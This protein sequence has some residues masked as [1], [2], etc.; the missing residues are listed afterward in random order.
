ML[1][2][3][4]VSNFRSIQEEIVLSLESGASKDLLDNCFVPAG[5][6]ELRLLKSAVLYGPNASGKSNV[7][8]A[9]Y[10]MHFFV[11]NSESFQ[12]GENIPCYDPF[13]LEPGA[14]S[15]PSAFRVKFIGSD[16]RIYIYQI[17]FNKEKIISETLDFYPTH[18]KAN[19]FTR[20]EDCE[21]KLGKYF[22]DK[23]IDKKIIK[24]RLFLSKAGNSGHLQMGEVFLYF[25]K[26]K[27]THL[28]N[29]G[30]LSQTLTE[31]SK[32]LYELS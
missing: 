11:M 24:N 21:I 31:I 2:E 14:N 18:V 15:L 32:V 10:A 25:R 27:V 29:K 30:G 3:F 1:I 7:L 9:I 6:N 26:F 23:K 22:E 16:N 4:A 20:T 5:D 19:L 12:N 17:I 8:R 13:L 28:M